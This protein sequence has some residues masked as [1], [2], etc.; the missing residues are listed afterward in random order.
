MELNDNDV[1]IPNQFVA[2]LIES[3]NDACRYVV[4]VWLL[5]SCLCRICFA[6]KILSNFKMYKMLNESHYRIISAMS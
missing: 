4:C 5:K 1:M 6:P 3:M 2:N